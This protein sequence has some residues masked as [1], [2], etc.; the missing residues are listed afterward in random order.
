MNP[1]RTHSRTSFYKYVGPTTAKKVLESGTLRW[2]SPSLFNDPFDVPKVI[3]DGITEAQLEA[4]MLKSF[5]SLLQNP[6]L[7]N[8][9]HLADLTKQILAFAATASEAEKRRMIETARADKSDGPKR[10][11]KEFQAE[12]HR[13]YENQRILCLSET[14]NSASMWDRYADRHQ[15]AVLELGCYDFA[16]S[17]WSRAKPVVY[18]DAPLSSNSADG[19]A[20]FFLYERTYALHQL[21][22][23]FTHTKTVD[24]AYE[25]EWRMAWWKVDPSSTGSHTDRPFATAELQSVT[26]GTH[27]PEATQ[28]DLTKLLVTRYPYTARW[29]AEVG[30]GR[31]LNRTR[32]R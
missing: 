27:M 32:V 24:W 26:F 2:S 13:L 7:P 5:L 29:K 1:S 11:V 22:E 12:W 21:M 3:F 8:P 4:A 30:A 31:S 6:A 9:E 23:E 20:R 19:I 17:A 14:W 25:R 28:Q 16:A 18:S 15:G 10:F